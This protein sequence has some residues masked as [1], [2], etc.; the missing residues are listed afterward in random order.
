MNLDVKFQGP[1]EGV[2][3]HLPRIVTTNIAKV[4]AAAAAVVL[5]L[6]I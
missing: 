6:P 2:D 1:E 4:P 5:C 3:G